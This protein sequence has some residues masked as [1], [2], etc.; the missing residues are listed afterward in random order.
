MGVRHIPHSQQRVL[1]QRH[2]VRKIGQVRQTEDGCIQRL[3][4]APALEALAQGVLIL[5]VHL[6]IRHDPHH[7]QMSLLFQHRKAGAE[8]LHIA[9]EFV[10]DKPLDARPL[11]FFQQLHRAVKLG[12]HAAPVD[13]AHQKH[14]RIHHLGKAHV[15]DVLAFQVYL[16][17]AACALDDDDVS[18][19]GQT[20]ICGHDVRHQLFFRAEILRRRHLAPHLT[21]D[22]DLTAHVAAGLQEDRV[23]PHVRLDAGRLRLH[24]LR[25]AHLKAVLGDEAVQG[26]VL[27]LEGHGVQAVLRKDAAERRA[28]QAFA[29]A[30]HR[31]LHH[32][33]FCS[34][35]SSTSLMISSSRAFSGAVRTAVRYHSG[36]RPG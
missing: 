21:V 24:H 14:R 17:R 33:A 4:S 1:L 32:D 12:E 10:D 2:E 18:L 20:I 9:P 26:H 29:R 27:A 22:D 34:A 28:E 3:F 13:V 35:H 19:L 16:R 7:R 31:A 36:P 23:H 11:F 8:D 25:P 5:D 15:H 6:Q 30:A